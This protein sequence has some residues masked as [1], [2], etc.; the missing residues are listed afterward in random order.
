MGGLLT[1]PAFLGA[2]PQVNTLEST[3][4]HTAWVTGLT[5]GAWNLGCIIS[6]ILSIF[7]SDLLGRR[8]TVLIGITIWTVGEIIQTTSYS[9]SQFIVGR[10]IA[11]FGN[12]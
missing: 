6:A 1:V 2:F 3:S 10:A 9:F 12:F 5:V 11:G 4:S 8:R 7:I